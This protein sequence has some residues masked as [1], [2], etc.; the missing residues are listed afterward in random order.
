M[1]VHVDVEVDCCDDRDHRFV[2]LV[3]HI[4]LMTEQT[5]PV[6][7]TPQYARHLR[8]V[9]ESLMAVQKMTVTQNV[10]I[11]IDPNDIKDKKGN[12]AKLDGPPS[13]GTDNSDLLALTPAD[14]GMSCK[15]SAVGLI[16]TCTL[17]V[18]GDG[19][20]GPGVS[21]ALGSLGFEIA[22]GNAAVITIN[23]GTPTEQ[24]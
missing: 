3:P 12:V 2:R 15:V 4:G 14:D 6:V 23:P 20:L 13:W 18:S 16:G 1:K 19:D 17:Q 22:A 11:T 24:P 21:L 9:K 10:V 5:S 8:L 7:K